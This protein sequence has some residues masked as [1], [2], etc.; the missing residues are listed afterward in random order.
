MVTHVVLECLDCKYKN[1]YIKRTSDGKRCEQ[2]DS[3]MFFPIDEGV[4]SEMEF[5]HFDNEI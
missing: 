5:K 1:I 4:K 3:R 2:C